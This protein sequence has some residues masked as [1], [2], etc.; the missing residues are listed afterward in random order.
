MVAPKENPKDHLQLRRYERLH[1]DAPLSETLLLCLR[2]GLFKPQYT[3]LILNSLTE[4]E[5]SL[6]HN[7]DTSLR[8]AFP[9][10]AQRD[11]SHDDSFLQNGCS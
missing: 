8:K 1:Q 2:I 5:G 10:L 3:G 9:K 6:L 11:L 7:T 4:P